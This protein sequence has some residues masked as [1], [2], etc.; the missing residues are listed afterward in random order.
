MTCVAT[1]VSFGPR[2]GAGEGNEPGPGPACDS[3][4]ITLVP[5]D[6]SLSRDLSLCKQGFDFLPSGS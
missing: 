4:G 3:G 2:L 1:W 6:S 5:M